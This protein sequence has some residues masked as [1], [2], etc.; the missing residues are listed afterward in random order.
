MNNDYPDELQGKYLY[1]YGLLQALFVQEDAIDS[2]H[3]ALFGGKVDFENNYPKVFEIRE[4]RNDVVGHPTNRKGTRFVYLVQMS[5]GKNSFS[6]VLNDSK[7]GSFQCTEVDVIEAIYQQSMCING[8]LKDAVL[9][10]DSEFKEYIE[11]HRDRKMKEIFS[12][13]DHARKKVLLKD[14]MGQHE[15]E[16]TKNMVK[17]FENEIIL[18]YGSLEAVDSYKY[19]LDE[20]HEIYELIDDGISQVPYELQAQF[21]KYLLQMLF[22]KLETLRSF[23]EETDEY[24]ETSGEC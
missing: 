6:Y 2:I 4:A 20:I 19:I 14:F 17:Q 24:F 23:C 5:L 7:T 8:I 16:N 13:L 10:L 9:Q 22:K 11:R 21:E 18:R 1:T 15:Y 3:V 12:L